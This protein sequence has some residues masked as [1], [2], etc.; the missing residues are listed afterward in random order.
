MMWPAEMLLAP[1]SLFSHHSHRI[2]IDSLAP[3][4]NP[5]GIT[6]RELCRNCDT[7]PVLAAKTDFIDDSLLLILWNLLKTQLGWKI[8]AY[9]LARHFFAHPLI[10]VDADMSAMKF[11]RLRRRAGTQGAA[12]GLV[13]ET[14]RRCFIDAGTLYGIGLRRL[15][16]R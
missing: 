10:R 11:S 15:L 5:H 1:E 7:K 12:A 14:I 9:R 8:P 2:D 3:H 4:W 16:C 6:T 13:K